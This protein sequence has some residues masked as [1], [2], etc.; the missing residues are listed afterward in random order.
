[1]RNRRF[2]VPINYK[3]AGPIFFVGLFL[4][5]FD[6]LSNTGEVLLIGLC[7]YIVFGRKR[8]DSLTPE[9]DK[10]PPPKERP[11]Q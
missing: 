1:M 11:C 4:T 10:R 3:I 9:N 7:I 8:R 5:M 2:G 6:V